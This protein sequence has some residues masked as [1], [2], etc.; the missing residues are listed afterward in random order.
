MS[1]VCLA[2]EVTYVNPGVI[3]ISPSVPNK[4]GSKC[5]YP[6]PIDLSVD[7]A[8]SNRDNYGTPVPVKCAKGDTMNYDR[9]M[10]YCVSQYSGYAYKGMVAPP[11]S[12]KFPKYRCEQQWNQSVCIPPHPGVNWTTCTGGDNDFICSPIED[13]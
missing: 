11:N 9:G 1:S 8:V 4:D 13:K 3:C 10:W 7:W 2:K 6:S 5:V 12:I